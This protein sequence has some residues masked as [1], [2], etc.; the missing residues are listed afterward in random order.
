MHGAADFA[1]RS[2]R[3]LEDGCVDDAFAAAEAGLALAPDDPV[4]CY[5]AGLAAA[6]LHRDDAALAHLDRVAD[7]DS[8]AAPALALRAEIERRSGDLDAALVTLQRLSSLPAADA[9]VVQHASFGLATALLAA[10]RVGDAGRA[11]ELALR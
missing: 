1:R 9:A 4:L 3:L 10:G 11:A 6:R 5:N 8:H 7:G 2:H